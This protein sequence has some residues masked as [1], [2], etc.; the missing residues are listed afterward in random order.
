MTEFIIKWE[1]EFRDLKDSRPG[2]VAENQRSFS[3]EENNINRTKPEAIHQNNG[4]ITPRL[5]VPQLT[6]GAQECQMPEERKYVKRGLGHLGDFEVPDQGPSQVSAHCILVQH[7]LVTQ[8][9]AQ[10]RLSSAWV[11]A[12]EGTRCK[13]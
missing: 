9:T 4:R 5:S 7:S 12:S 13:S 6:S 8:T 11:P 1:T 3:E 10:E 2:G